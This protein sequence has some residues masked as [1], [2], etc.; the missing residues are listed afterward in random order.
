MRLEHHHIF[1]PKP[2]CT[3][4]SSSSR[5]PTE[6]V[7][8]R[9]RCGHRAPPPTPCPPHHQCIFEG[10]PTHLVQILVLAFSGVPLKPAL[11]PESRPPL[12][13]S[14]PWP[15]LLPLSMRLTRAETFAEGR[16]EAVHLGLRQAQ[17]AWA[18]KVREVE[19][20]TLH[21]EIRNTSSSLF[22]LNIRFVC[23]RNYSRD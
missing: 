12:M 15:H 5:P 6:S 20:K 23:H 7:T 10:T 4:G 9:K 16:I 19:R 21:E 14:D 2:A 3:L 22:Q 11:P 8:R 17:L 1:H 13:G 18:C